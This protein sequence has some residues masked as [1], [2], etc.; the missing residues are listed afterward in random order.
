MRALILAAA[1]VA[2]ISVLA[3][4]PSVAEEGADGHI[5]VSSGAGGIA[6]CTGAGFAEY[7]P[8]PDVGFRGFA[9]VG[10]YGRPVLIDAEE[11]E[12][13]L[14]RLQVV[15]GS[16][17]SDGQGRM[18]N[19]RVELES[20]LAIDPSCFAHAVVGVLDDPRGW[21]GPGRRFRRVDGGTYDLSI[22]L[23]SPATTDELCW[24]LRTG[25]VLSC[26]RGNRVIV[27]F[28]RWMNGG[29]AFGADLSG[30]RSYLINHEVGHF[31]GLGHAD[32]PAE[33][34]TAPVMMQQTKGVG[35]CVA[36]GWPLPSELGG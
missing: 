30:Y 12:V 13:P 27:N 6:H 17:N 34:A 26:R 28:Y 31:L 4:V 16:T 32:C 14:S 36:N 15:P 11:V 10:R 33:G 7:R 35:D 19:F 1:A 8:S 18:V 24:P 21:S 29:E 20:G 23:A 5:V 2:L 9:E 22:T 3:S 25:G